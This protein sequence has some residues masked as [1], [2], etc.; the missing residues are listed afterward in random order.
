MPYVL[1]EPYLANGTLVEFTS[2]PQLTFVMSIALH[3]SK[4]LTPAMQA[5]SS[6]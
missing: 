2:A 1:V 3:K 6:T 5:M 4:V